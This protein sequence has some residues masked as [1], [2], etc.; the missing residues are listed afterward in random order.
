MCKLTFI[1]QGAEWILLFIL[2][3]VSGCNPISVPNGNISTK[4]PMLET[5]LPLLD[6]SLTPAIVFTPILKD[7]IT[8]TH[9]PSNIPTLLSSTP[10]FTPIIVPTP[11]LTPPITL[12]PEQA[13]NEIL[14][15]LKTPLNCPFPCFWGITPKTTTLGEADNLFQHLGYSLNQSPVDKHIFTVS[16]YAQGLNGL[17]LHIE[18]VDQNGLVNNLMARIFLGNYKGAATPRVWAAFSPENVLLQYGKPSNV[19]FALF[20]PTEPGFPEGIAWYQMSVQYD[21]YPYAVVYFF[22]E[23]RDEKSIHICPLSDKFDTV[24]IYFGFDPATYASKGILG[25]PIEDVSSLNIDQFYPLMTKGKGSA[26][27][28]LNADALK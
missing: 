18:L 19:T 23:V 12:E 7:T 15:L 10:S 1:S 25:T 5:Q 28:D 9:A 20:Y 16:P 26:C 24:D 13:T 14:A 8:P 6:N 4:D 11:T 17:S 22:A 27:F 3:L 21:Q 2:L